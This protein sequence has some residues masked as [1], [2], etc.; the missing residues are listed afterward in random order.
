MSFTGDRFRMWRL[1]WPPMKQLLSQGIA[2]RVVSMPCCE[3]FAQQDHDYRDYV[4][5][6][7][8]T[9]RVAI[10]AAAPQFWYQFV[11]R[12]ALS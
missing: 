5:P 7:A 12:K 11:A 2:V 1:Q 10:E 4:L 9:C 6:P 3:V 8:V